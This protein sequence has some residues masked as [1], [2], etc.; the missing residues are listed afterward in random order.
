MRRGDRWRGQ[1]VSEEVKQKQA[2]DCFPPSPAPPS[3]RDS[4]GQ[5]FCAR[6][7]PSS[8]GNRHFYSFFLFFLV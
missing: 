6:L 3:S 1:A 7:Q 2:E 8:L 5:C 4:A